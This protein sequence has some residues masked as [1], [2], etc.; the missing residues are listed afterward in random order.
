MK[1]LSITKVTGIVFCV[2]A[3]GSL[4]LDFF[5]IKCLFQ[6]GVCKTFFVNWCFGHRGEGRDV[7]YHGGFDK[8]KSV[9]FPL[10]EGFPSITARVFD[11]PPVL[12]DYSDI[13]ESSEHGSAILYVIDNNFSGIDFFNF[14]GS[15]FDLGYPS[16]DFK[17]CGL[18]VVEPLVDSSMRTYANFH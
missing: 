11:V 8:L 4:D 10:I 2:G 5:K 16:I 1:I 6:G 7:E 12:K 15:Q 9:L 18:S 17:S 14:L 13:L 3:Q